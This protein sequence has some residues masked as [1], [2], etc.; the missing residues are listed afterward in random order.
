MKALYT[1]GLQGALPY[2]RIW[3]VQ[4]LSIFAILMVGSPSDSTDNSERVELEFV[5][6]YVFLGNEYLVTDKIDED[7]GCLLQR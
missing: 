2:G 5:Q 4:L 1:H 6:C 3:K 7:L